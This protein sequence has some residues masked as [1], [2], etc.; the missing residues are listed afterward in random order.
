MDNQ[1]AIVKSTALLRRV[2][3]KERLVDDPEFESRSLQRSASR[4][5][6]NLLFARAWGRQALS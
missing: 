6:A 3:E 2:V 4:R 1:I 5:R